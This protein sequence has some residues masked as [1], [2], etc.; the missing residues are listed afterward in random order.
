M[1]VT[2]PSPTRN[3]MFQYDETLANLVFDYCR[4]RLSLEPVPLDFGGS[5]AL[6]PALLAGLIGAKPN[7]PEKILSVFSEHLAT[8]IVSADSP[9]FLS[10]IP[11]VPTKASLLF[12]MIV[13][14]SC[15]QGTSWLE[16]AGAVLA[17][18]QALRVLADLAGLPASA[19]GG[20]VRWATS[21]RWSWR[22]TPPRAAWMASSLPGRGSSSATR[23]TRRWPRH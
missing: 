16:A 12:D 3:P 11:A 8:A 23:P 18:N 22:V 9:R 2:E 1:G 20:F 13:S 6:S 15:L 21:R 5:A 17:E 19:G 7:D 10:F 14:C 4:R